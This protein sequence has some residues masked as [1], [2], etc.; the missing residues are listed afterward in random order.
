VILLDTHVVLWLAFEPRKISRKANL[1]I[2]EARKANEGAAISGI[3]L[4]EI[5]TAPRKGQI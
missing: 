1:R 5:A 2:E 4:L 3:T